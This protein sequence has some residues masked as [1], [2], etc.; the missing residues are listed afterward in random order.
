MGTQ[1]LPDGS[2]FSCGDSP[3]SITAS[4]LGILTFIYAVSVGLRFYYVSL[5]NAEEQMIATIESL[6]KSFQEARDIYSTLNMPPEHFT[7]GPR[8]QD[9]NAKEMLDDA[10]RQ[11]KELTAMVQRLSFHDSYGSLR[12]L[13]RRRVRFIILQEELQK[14]IAEKDEMMGNLRQFRLR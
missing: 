14:K 6:K 11:L 12:K 3:L 13:W 10:M 8:P 7:S 9:E 5:L 1:Q 4:I 2:C